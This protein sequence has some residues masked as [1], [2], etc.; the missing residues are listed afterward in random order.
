MS[1]AP[2]ITLTSDFGDAGYYVGAMRGVL[3][4][5]CPEACLV[6][7]THR[8][9]PYSPLEGSLV[10]FQACTT[11]P[12]GTVHLAVVDPGVGGL[13]KPIFVR[14]R[15]YF[16]VGPDNGIFTPFLDGTESVYRI[17]DE[18]ALPGRS[19]TFH[20]RDLFAPAAARLARGDDPETVG[21]RTHQA[22][23]LHVPRP[24]RD[25]SLMVGQVLYVDHFGNLITNIHRNDLAGLGTDLAVT[26]GTH[27]IRC[28]SRTYQDGALGESLALV[29]SS[30]Y[31]EVA[32]V[33]GNAGAQ[34]GMG[35]G[36]RVRV[37]P[38]ESR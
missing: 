18:V 31:L 22:V 25:G 16:F 38:V 11:F 17:R 15:G 9:A 8:V 20:G 6:D 30:G 29:G 34:L 28:L 5:L 35:K 7:L 4:S 23:H 2:I 24:R 12:E 21:E 27:E 10:L 13:R 36:E 26:V 37:R 19:E 3:L 1:R 33:Q 14:A 32:V